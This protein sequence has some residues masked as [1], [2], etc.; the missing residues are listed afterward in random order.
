MQLIILFSNAKFTANNNNNINNN[1]N[2][3]IVF[4]TEILNSNSMNKQSTIKDIKNL[5][6]INYKDEF[7]GYAGHYTVPAQHNPNYD[8]HIY[9]WYQPCSDCEDETKAPLLFWLQGGPGGPGWF[10]AFAELE[11]GILVAIQAMLNRIKDAFLGVQR[12]IVYLLI[13]QLILGF[14]FKQIV[15]LEK[16]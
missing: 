14:H 2:E 9:T 5:T 3:N 13:N 4:I 7:Y 6:A 1:N 10:G 16:Q 12:I 11:I 15:Q 8:N